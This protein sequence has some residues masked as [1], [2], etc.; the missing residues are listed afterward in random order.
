MLY[1]KKNFWPQILSGEKRTTIRRWTT[2]RVK[3]NSRCYAP[4]IGWLRI[5][6]IEQID[7]NR[8]TLADARADGFKSL[9]ALRSTLD[10]LY[11]DRATDGR[12]WFR[13]TFRTE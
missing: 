13:V 9:R 2:P 12:S 7:L 11:P 10:E 8:L 5:D 6:A 4:G 3:S 1:F